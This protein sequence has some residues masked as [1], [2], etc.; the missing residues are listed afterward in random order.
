[1]DGIITELLRLEGA[2][3]SALIEGNAPAYDEHVRAQLRLL[4]SATDLESAARKSPK[5]LDALSK[6]LRLNTALFR[7]LVSTSSLFL[8]NQ[9]GYT[10][11]GNMETRVGRRIAVEA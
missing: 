2:K 9:I 10:S 4:D 6:L 3:R 8:L 7:N 1:M 11:T 5:D